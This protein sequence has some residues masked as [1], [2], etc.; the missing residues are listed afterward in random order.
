MN[1]LIFFFPKEPVI[2]KSKEQKLIK[3]E[4]PFVDESLG[5]AFIKVL[6][7]N[8]HTTMMIKVKFTR[9][10]AI[11]DLTHNGSETVLIDLKE[12][13]GVLDLRSMG[14]YKIKQ[15]IIEQNLRKYIRFESADII[16]EHFNRFINTLKTGRKEEMQEKYPWLDLSDERKYITDKEILDKCID[17]NKSCLM[18]TEKQQVMDML[19]KYKDAFSLRDEIGICPNIEIEIDITNESPFFMRP[20]HVKEEG[21]NFIY[22]EMKRLCYLGILKEGFSP[23]SSPFMLIGKKVMKDKRVVTDFRHINIRIAKIN[24]AYSLLKDIFSVLDKSHCEFYQC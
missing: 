18:D 15:G 5:I 3:V 19:Y 13:L 23:Y 6:D 10:L 22:K 24:L 16:C 11:I 9:N 8:M 12:M 4:A 20:Y 2:V 1:R 7:K 17:L 21:I 14:Y